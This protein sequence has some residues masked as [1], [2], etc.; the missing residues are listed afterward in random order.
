MTRTRAFVA[1]GSVVALIFLSSTA[2]AKETLVIV[3]QSVHPL[4]FQLPANNLIPM[5]VFPLAQPLHGDG[6]LLNSR[7]RA[8]DASGP[9]IGVM[10]GQCTN[11][12]S[13][14][15]V[16]PNTNQSLATFMMQCLHTIQINGR[17][18]LV[19]AGLSNLLEFEGTADQCYTNGA[20]QTLAITGGTGD[21]KRSRGEATITALPNHP[22][23]ALG[24][25]APT[26]ATCRPG[27]VK[28]IVLK[29]Q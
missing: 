7:V 6:L 10:H 13:T 23:C 29:I 20:A 8:G 15:V 22:G 18:S 25:T 2:R 17:G 4:V 9:A 27:P 24:C 3:E 11:I 21:F 12:G 1:L 19:I 5:P 26:A 14:Q 28:Q 16:P